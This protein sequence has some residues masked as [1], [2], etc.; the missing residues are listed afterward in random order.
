MR[1]GELFLKTH[2][3]NQVALWQSE[4]C[5]DHTAEKPLQEVSGEV[6]RNQI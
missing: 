4:I 3:G 5:Q 1:F 2:Q 6:Q